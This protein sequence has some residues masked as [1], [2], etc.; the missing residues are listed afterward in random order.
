MRTEYHYPT[1]IPTQPPPPPVPQLGT[2]YT[3]SAVVEKHHD[4]ES[5]LCTQWRRRQVT[6]VDMMFI[7]TRIVREGKM[8]EF[9]RMITDLIDGSPADVSYE[10]EFRP[11]RFIH[12]WQFV[13]SA[14]KNPVF[15]LPSDAAEIIKEKE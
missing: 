11:S 15:V 9:E 4:P 3:V 10:R 1:P 2:W 14:H 5:V 13:A 8:H 7:G 12:V 6:P